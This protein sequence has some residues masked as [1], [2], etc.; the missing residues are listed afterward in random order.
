MSWARADTDGLVL[1]GRQLWAVQT[2]LNKISRWQLSDDLSRGTLDKVITDPLFRVPLTAVKFGNRLAVANSH[3]DS[4]Y[5]PTNPD[6]RGAR[7][8]RV[9]RAPKYLISSHRR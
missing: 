2:F 8:R 6:V 3:L 5:P 7:G 1:D 4:G 9:T